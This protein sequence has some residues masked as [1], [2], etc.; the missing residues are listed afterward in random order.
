VILNGDDTVPEVVWTPLSVMSVVPLLF[1]DGVTE[2][3]MASCIS[4]RD[5]RKNVTRTSG[6]LSRFPPFILCIAGLA[7]GSIALFKPHGAG[8]LKKSGYALSIELGAPSKGTRNLGLREL[9]SLR[10]IR[11]PSL[12][13][14][15]AAEEI[16]CAVKIFLE[17]AGIGA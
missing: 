15:E 3:A 7:D 17:G 9:E 1:E 14:H 8:F 6:L 10:L 12:D 11:P 5:N 13:T 16:G 2:E 4:L